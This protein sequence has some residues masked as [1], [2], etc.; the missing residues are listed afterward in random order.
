MYAQLAHACTW[1]QRSCAPGCR[2]QEQAAHVGPL[3]DQEEMLSSRLVPEEPLH[4]QYAV[5]LALV[6]VGVVVVVVE[7]EVT[8]ALVQHHL[9]RLVVP[10]VG[11]GCGRILRRGRLRRPR[12][13]LLVLGG[14]FERL[15]LGHELIVDQRLVHERHLRHPN[16]ACHRRRLL[17]LGLAGVHVAHPQLVH[18]PDSPLAY[19]RPFHD[20]LLYGLAAVLRPGARRHPELDPTS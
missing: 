20:R 17:G 19:D 7:L 2:E 8:Q 4:R 11:C 6:E 16:L 3:T 13:R 15:D 10:R 12:L 14:R 5:V 9:H 1:E 18:R